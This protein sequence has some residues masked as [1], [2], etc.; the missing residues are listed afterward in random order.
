ML[1]REKKFVEGAPVSLK[2]PGPDGAKWE[3]AMEAGLGGRNITSNTGTR[4]LL[5]ALVFNL[6][7]RTKVL[8]GL[9]GPRSLCVSP[10]VGE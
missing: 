8:F 6:R 4:V 3:Q 2:Q 7:F 10:L 1:C 5:D 9:T